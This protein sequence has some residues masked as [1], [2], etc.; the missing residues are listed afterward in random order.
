VGEWK[1]DQLATGLQDFIICIEMFIL[2]LVHVFVFPYQPYR[3]YHA[4]W[5]NSDETLAAIR[6]PAKNFSVVVD[7][8]DIF[9]D[10]RTVYDPLHIKEAKKQQRELTLRDEEEIDLLMNIDAEE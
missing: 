8:K 5:F 10:L 7:Q 2:S 9:L 3:D 1:K 6:G 4:P